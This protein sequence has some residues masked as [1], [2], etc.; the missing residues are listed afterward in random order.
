MSTNVIGENPW[1]PGLTVNTFVPD[2]LIA[3]DLKLVTD[4]VSIGGSAVV[5]RG[6]VMGRITSS[7]V[8]IPSV[9]TATDGSQV[10]S[11]IMVDQVDN[12]VTTPQI[13]G[14]YLMGEF[15][16]NSLIYDASWGTAGSSAAYQAL[17]GAF[18]PSNIFLKLPNSAAD[19]SN[20]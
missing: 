12:T 18:I 11:A 15:N 13:G 9:A 10:P 7:G 16:F 4:S 20:A 3:G 8:Y 2:Q 14:I 19:A 5:A 1:I 17:K 6:T